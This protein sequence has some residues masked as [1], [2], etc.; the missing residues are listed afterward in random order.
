MSNY[1][2]D[3][4]PIGMSFDEPLNKQCECGEELDNEEY[5]YCI[6]CHDYYI[7]EDKINDINNELS[8]IAIVAR[9]NKEH[10]LEFR[11]LETIEELKKI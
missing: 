5:N 8:R 2:T 4:D 3:I 10:D 11:I 9:K 1:L 6:N 7:R